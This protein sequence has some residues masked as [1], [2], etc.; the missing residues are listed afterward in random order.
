MYRNREVFPESPLA[1]V[2]AEIRFSDSARLRQQPTLD[3]VA[4]ALEDLFPYA[5]PLQQTDVNFS[6]MPGTAPQ[7]QQHQRT[8]LMLKNAAKTES[9]S[10]VPS[11]LTYETT[12]YA[13]FHDLLN[14]VTTACSA[15][16]EV[17]VRP[18]I[19]RIGLR[20]IDE[21]RVP[22]SVTDG[23][24]WARWIDAGLIEHLHVGPE[25]AP[26]TGMQGVTTYDLGSGK[27]LN[28][29][30]AAL[31]QAPVVVPQHL[32]PR[33]EPRVGPF[34]VL[35][36]DG[37]QDFGGQVA[38]PLDPEVVGRCLT[39]VHAPSGATFQH[40]ITDDARQLFRGNLT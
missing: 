5:E 34:F 19:E 36:I 39:A 3:A 14:A 33:R 6:L 38:T 9:L 20:Y 10:L 8:G 37:Y 16:L 4:I 23:R 40:A 12:A 22:E 21:V 35:D 7:V 24:Q 25:N 11:A 30:F 1:L 18:A 32:I 15:L 28:F 31:N 2:A 17:N 29:R 13:T 27:R 26:V